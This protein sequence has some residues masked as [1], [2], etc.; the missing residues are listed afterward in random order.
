MDDFKAYCKQVIDTHCGGLG[1]GAFTEGTIWRG[2]ALCREEIEKHIR[3][4]RR[5]RKEQEDMYYTSTEM[6]RREGFRLFRI[7][8]AEKQER[9]KHVDLPIPKAWQ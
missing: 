7:Y 3:S 4:R 5:P 2:L 1:S 8:K 9:E 6:I